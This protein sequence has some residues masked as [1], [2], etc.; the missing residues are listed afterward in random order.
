[1]RPLVVLLFWAGMGL[2]ASG[3]ASMSEKAC[4]VGDWA[5]YGQVDARKGRLKDYWKRHQRA[6]GEY[7]TQVDVQAYESGWQSGLSEF[8]QPES[9]YGHGAMGKSYYGQCAGLDEKVFKKNFALG[10]KVYLLKKSREELDGQMESMNGESSEVSG[11]SVVGAIVGIISE[12]AKQGRRSQL[13]E[14]RA[15][16]TEE[17]YQ[18]ESQAPAVSLSQEELSPSM[19]KSVGGTVTGMIVG[20][21]AGHAIQGRYWDK[22]WIFTAGEGAAVGG[23]ILSASQCDTKQAETKVGG[24]AVQTQVH[25][26]CQGVLPLLSILGFIGMR[27]WQSVDLITHTGQASNGYLDHLEAEV[28]KPAW[29]VGVYLPKAESPPSLGLQFNW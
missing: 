26:E 4:E 10:R 29:S 6:C 1:M 11:N 2:L 21:G 24:T 8:C 14:K 7:N 25:R 23:L 15:E 16:M 17:I 5:Q 20:F 13:S 22:G 18:L 12:T 9:A 3:C 19:W 28:A 27:I